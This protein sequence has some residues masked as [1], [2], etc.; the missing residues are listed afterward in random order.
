MHASTLLQDL[1]A[2]SNILLNGAKD[3]ISHSEGL[4]E[5]L[6]G[7]ELIGRAN[8]VI[9]E[10]DVARFEIASQGCQNEERRRIQIGVQVNHQSSREIVTA[11]KG[12]K[13]LLEKT[14]L[15]TAARVIR[16]GN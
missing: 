4:D 9:E 16:L 12:K 5:I 13:C 10:D 15:E 2:D 6:E 8:E 14:D 11:G 7:A 1:D 3:F